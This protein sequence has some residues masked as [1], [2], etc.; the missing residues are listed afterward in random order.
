[1]NLLGLLRG[2]GF[3]GAYGPDR[4][5]GNHGLAERGNPGE[6]Q[7][8][9]ELGTDNRLGLPA[10]AMLQQLANAENRQQ[11]RRLRGNELA[12]DPLVRFRVV[13]AS[14]GMTDQHVIAADVLQHRAGHFAGIGTLRMFAEILRTEAKPATAACCNQLGQVRERWNHGDI[15]S[16]RQCC[17]QI[18]HQ[19]GGIPARAMHFPVS[20]YEFATHVL[21][22]S[23]A[24]GAKHSRACR[25]RQTTC[26]EPAQNAR[27]G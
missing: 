24:T 1:M 5:V 20:G 11:A 19:R 12:R 3:P 23:W 16:H 10:F 9:I 15:R 4:L 8:G 21:D 26:A 25:L 7:H 14:F 17:G 18:L 22:R 2:R 6:I 13:L 27:T